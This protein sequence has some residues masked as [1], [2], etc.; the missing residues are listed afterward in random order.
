MNSVE[1]DFHVSFIV[2]CKNL[3][4]LKNHD[5]CTKCIETFVGQH[6]IKYSDFRCSRITTANNSKQF[7]ISFS[8]LCKKPDCTQSLPRNV[9]CCTS[10]P[11]KCEY[12]LR[13]IVNRGII[14]MDGFHAKEVNIVQL[15]NRFIIRCLTFCNMKSCRSAESPELFF[16][17]SGR[18]L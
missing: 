3:K 1:K 10:S 17:Q 18:L 11:E 5:S 13:S 14:A 2:S 16:L 6:V 15:K 12:C 8:L 4:C 7:G 9:A